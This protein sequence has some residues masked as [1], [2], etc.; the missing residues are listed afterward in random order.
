MAKYSFMLPM[1]AVALLSG[2]GG[3]EKSEKAPTVR[4]VTA[5]IETIGN[6]TSGTTVQLTGTVRPMFQADL[7]S[8]LLARVI[9]VSGRPGDRVRQGQ[10]LVRLDARELSSA[11]AM[12]SANLRSSQVGVTS[13]QT[14]ASMEAK[15]SAA[16]IKQAEAAVV[17]A[18]AGLSAAQAQQDLVQAG[19]R[20]Q[21]KQQAH[22]AVVQAKSNLDLAEKEL[23]RAR[24]LE[25]G[26]VIPRRE[27]E[28]AENAYEV[29]KAA[30]QTALEGE[31]IAVEGAREQELRAAK[32]AVEQARAALRQAEA[33]LNQAKAASMMIEVRRDD[34]QSARAQVNQ[35][36]AALQSARV[37]LAYATI[38]AP[39]D[40][41]IVSRSADPGA[42]AAPGSPILSVEGAPYRLEVPVPESLVGRL[43]VGSSLTAT[44]EQGKL[45]LVGSVTEIVPQGDAASRT[46]LVKVTFQE[47]GG[48]KS[49]QFGQVSVPIPTGSTLLAPA[50]AI[51]EREGLHYAYALDEKGLARLRVVVVG[52]KLG[53]QVEILSGLNAGERVVTTG[54]DAVREGDLVQGST[55]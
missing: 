27:R 13:A 19:P 49:G 45:R 52:K 2:C 35:S 44:F 33:G 50:P 48:L 23:D 26:G 41:T 36:G 54:R 1:A 8:K 17:Q 4:T 53:E 55:K 6:P 40:G 18:R 7:A 31:K 22:L 42:M 38:T 51:W 10:V 25:E 29:A 3:P 11:V 20:T 12:A 43:S 15:T 46:F 47:P 39:F 16:R 28:M 14:A 30:Y 24:K 9:S 5:G 37:S 34:I 32:Q 21:Q